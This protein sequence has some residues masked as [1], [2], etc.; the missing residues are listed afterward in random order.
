MCVGEDC[1]DGSDE[2]LT[3]KCMDTCPALAKVR[4]LKAKALAEVQLQVSIIFIIYYCCCPLFFLP[5]FFFSSFFV[6]YG[7]DRGGG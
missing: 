2:L 6:A 3:G 1:C 4:Q 5:V 7:G